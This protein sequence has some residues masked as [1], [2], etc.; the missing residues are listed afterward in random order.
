MSSTQVRRRY[1]DTTAGQM[2]L[3]E[4]G[5]GP[6]LVLLHWVPLSGRLYDHELPAFGAAGFHT[7]AVDLMGFGRSAHH[8]G[9]W[10]FQQ[11]AEALQEGLASAGIEQCGLLGGH[12]S[13]PIALELTV[14][15][16]TDVWALAIDGSA[17]LMPAE[18]LQD[19]GNK[20]T[21]FAGP[22]LHADGSHRH[23]L[24][25]QAINACQVFNPD[26][27]LSE[28]NVNLVYGFTLDYLS[29][30]PAADFGSFSAYPAA[31]RLAAVE[32]PLMILT[33]ETDPL[34]PAYEPS[35]AAA[36]DAAVGRVIAGA[37]PLHNLARQG[38][39]AAEVT[40]FF[41]RIPQS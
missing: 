38:E 2:H 32:C 17:H 6:T 3:T 16:A 25:D 35:L 19:I 18:A 30:G 40:E 14:N 34:Y 39:Y 15:G 29:T 20:S 8:E 21:K 23:F 31:E 22:G 37:H 11:H 5:A 12:F 36:G 24:W 4:A 7:V 28:D 33:A 27:E 10:S 41:R 1:V 9:V 13:A 26:F